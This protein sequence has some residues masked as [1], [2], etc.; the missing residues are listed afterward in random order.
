MDL[1]N[2]LRLAEL[3]LQA[4]RR[5]SP[6]PYPAAIPGP[7]E[8]A[9]AIHENSFI[10]HLRALGY[11]YEFLDDRDF[12][13]ERLRNARAICLSHVY[14]LSEEHLR[15]LAEFARRGGYVLAEAGTAIRD[16]D[17]RP[18]AK[19]PNGFRDLFGIERSTPA[20]LP[21]VESEALVSIDAQK[22][23]SSIADGDTYR[24]GKASFFNHR[25]KGNDETCALVREAFVKAGVVPTFRFE[26]NPIQPG[27]NHTGLPV[28]QVSVFRRGDLTYLVILAEGNAQHDAYR[29]RFPQAQEVYDVLEQ[30]SLGRRDVIDG[31]IRY[32]EVRMLALTPSLA[33]GLSVRCD[34]TAYRPVETV[35]VTISVST[36]KGNA[37]DRVVALTLTPHR[38]IMPVVPRCAMLN[39]GRMDL[40][41]H[42]PLNMSKGSYTLTARD[43]CSGITT[44]ARFAISP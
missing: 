38:D 31:S 40:P 9:T 8:N 2:D 10:V 4:E 44:N 37:G 24:K 41:I 21:P 26:T 33:T 18:Y 43:V 16:E 34:Q 14:C 3:L 22:V 42:I 15:M 19:S 7:F 25:L 13:A 28:A 6:G 11:Q 35:K 5:K 12:T 30:K 36:Q 29:L 39:A 27:A 1:N 17:G 32:G 23:A 20:L